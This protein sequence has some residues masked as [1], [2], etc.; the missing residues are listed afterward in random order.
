MWQ[1]YDIIDFEYYLHLD[2]SDNSAETQENQ[3]LRDRTFFLDEMEPEKKRPSRIDLFSAW[4]E[5]RKKQST[6][7]NYD[8]QPGE[9]TKEIFQLLR[10]LLICSG[11]LLGWGVGFSFFHYTG[12]APLNVFYFLAAFIFTQI[13]LVLFLFISTG[14]RAGK[15]VIPSSSLLYT[16]LEKG[17]LRLLYF[18]KKRIFKNLTASQ[19]L[20]FDYTWGTLQ[21]KKHYRSLFFWPLFTQMQLFGI[22]FNMSLLA[23]SLFNI[24]ATDLAFGWQSTIQFS[25]EAIHTFVRILATPW[26]WLLS[27]PYPSLAEIEGSRIILKDGIFNLTTPDLVSWWPFLLCSL[28]V[29]GLI[30]RVIFYFFGRYYQNKMLLQLNYDHASHDQLYQRMLTPHMTTQAEPEINID[31]S[32]LTIPISDVP[33][34]KHDSPANDLLTVIISGDIFSACTDEALNKILSS[35]GYRIEQKFPFGDDFEQDQRMVK[36]LADADY[37]NSAGILFLMEAWMPPI[38]DFTLFLQELREELP[39]PIVFRVSLIGKP[40]P[41]TIFTSANKVNFEIWQKKIHGLGD[42]YTR[43]EHLVTTPTGTI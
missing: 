26:S 43:V 31:Q 9:L 30:P 37:S 16:F 39:G 42:P 6:P 14:L 27:Q 3:H 33:E 15:K 40:T 36:N 28:T 1:L 12:T 23:V 11:L 21:G 38:S 7:T 25:N 17:F 41:E 35:K 8:L 4:L 10:V 5:F 32:I 2:Q 13:L 20:S 34:P 22:C 24:I 29:Y 19:R 18:S